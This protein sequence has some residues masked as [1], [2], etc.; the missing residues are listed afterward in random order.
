[1]I[2]PYVGTYFSQRFVMKDVLRMSDK[3]IQIMKTEIGQEPPPQ[4]INT[5]QPGN[6]PQ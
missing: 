6:P 5:E 1:M 4:Q 2:T 3:E